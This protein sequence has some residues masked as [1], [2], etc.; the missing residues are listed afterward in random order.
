MNIGNREQGKE[1]GG[2]G[3]SNMKTKKERRKNRK[4]IIE[5]EHKKSNTNNN[6][7]RRREREVIRALKS[8]SKEFLHPTDSLS[9]FSP[10]QLREKQEK[11]K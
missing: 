7:G 8:G 3:K 1:W 10:L 5:N 11:E 2:R 4:K 9:Y 6:S